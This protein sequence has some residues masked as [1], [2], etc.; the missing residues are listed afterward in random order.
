MKHKL[1]MCLLVGTMVLSSYGMMALAEETETE[2]AADAAASEDGA[3]LSDDLYSFQVKINGEVYQFPCSYADFTAKGW[4]LDGEESEEL[5]PNYY[6]SSSFKLGDLEASVELIN[7]GMNTITIPETIVAGITIDE[8]NYEDAP[9]TVIEMPCGITY[10]ISSLDDIVAAYG[11]ASDTYD[12]DLYTKL[13]YDY[14]S[15]QDIELYVSAETNVLNEISIRN[16]VE[17]EGSS[18]DDSDVEVSDEPTPEVLAYTAPTELGDDFQSFIVEFAGD[19]YQLPAPV[20]VFLENGWTLK[21]DDTEMVVAGKNTGWVSM[22]KDNQSFRTLARNYNGNAAAIQNCF[23]TS[24]EASVHG[25]NLPMTVQKGICLGMSEEDLMAALE[26]VEYEQEG[27]E[28]YL[29]YNIKNEE[30]TTDYVQVLLNTDEG[31]VTGLTSQYHPD[32]IG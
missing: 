22:I 9:D 16:F 20:S 15:Y 13:T 19:L 4:V 28:P 23:V 25:P 5:A 6:T 24:I 26:G 29:Y 1:L 32:S 14:A 10:G 17:P 8:W 27:E 2:T 18:S 7:L 30:Y 31:K 3:E 21:T 12:G 11:T